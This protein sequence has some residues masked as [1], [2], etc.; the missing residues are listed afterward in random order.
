MSQHNIA[1]TRRPVELALSGEIGQHVP[2]TRVFSIL[3]RRKLVVLGVMLATGLAATLLIGRMAPYYD[4]EATVMIHTGKTEFSDL[5]ASASGTSGDSIMIRTQTDIIRSPAMAKRVVDRL[6]LVNDPEFKGLLHA[7]ASMSR[8]IT[9]WLNERLDSAPV[10]PQALEPTIDLRNAAAA[11]LGSKVNVTN[12]GHSYLI[13]IRAR[14]RSPQLSA[15]IA[16]AYTQLYFDFNRDLKTAAIAR[17]GTLLD[18]QIA[19]LKTR[20]EATENAVETYRERNGLVVNRTGQEGGRGAT[21]ADQQLSQ[22]SAELIVASSSLSLKE[23]TLRAVQNAQ[24]G[25]G[26][27][28]AIPEVVSSPLVQRLREQE[29]ELSSRQASLSETTLD[30]N[31]ALQSVQAGL[32]DTR[33][34]TG[35]EISRIVS[36]LSNEVAV[37]RNRLDALRSTVAQLQGEVSS[38]SQATVALRQLES[39]ADAARTVYKDY[40]GRYEQTSNQAALQ[41][42]EADLVSGAEVPAVRSGPPRLQFLA[43][44]AIASLLTGAFAALGIERLRGG[45]RTPE[46]LEAQTG[47]F[48]LGFV[49]M[50]SRRERA[51]T[52]STS[53]YAASVDMVRSLLDYGGSS[54]SARVVVMTSALPGEGKSTLALALVAS[55]CHAGGRALL[56][57]CDRGRSS[58]AAMLRLSEDAPPPRVVARRSGGLPDSSYLGRGLLCWHRDVRPALDV[59]TL[60]RSDGQIGS[61][62]M[63]EL[64]PLLEAARETYDLVVLDAPP[65]LAKSNAATL[66]ALADGAILVVRWA[67]TP[68]GAV[69]AA[70]RLLQAYNIRVLGG[71]MTQVRVKDLAGSEGAHAL[72]YRNHSGYFG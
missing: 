43:I 53:A 12:D 71:V 10:A 67:F 39:E 36:S 57:D 18:A 59:V 24:H 33:R 35:A 13:G 61:T 62:L 38:Q 23:A 52:G 22:A 8:R 3:R 19:P 54:V 27:L 66:A 48:P 49:P 65:V 14:T 9:A 32:A 51:A 45:L 5:Q 44:A 46:D 7:P 64:R 21:V 11:I 16:N 40:L 60:A 6:D 70:S 72:L 20:V 50:G 29:T 26:G 41:E 28:S 37:A 58:V 56:I 1:L 47:L 31:P 34:R 30:N 25:G 2:P 15:A 55:A 69:N 4:A 68:A 63:A 17:G 42:P